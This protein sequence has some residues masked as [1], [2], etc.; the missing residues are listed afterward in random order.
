M[1]KEFK[2]FA[3]K[4]NVLDMAVGII[5]GAAFGKIISSLVADI[6]MPPVG[7]MMGGLDFSNLFLNL[8]GGEYPQG[9]QGRGR[10]DDQRG[11]VPQH[12]HRFLDC[13]DRD[14]FAGAQ[15]EPHASARRGSACGAVHEALPVVLVVEPASHSCNR[16][17]ANLVLAVRHPWVVDHGFVILERHAYEGDVLAVRRP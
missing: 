5:I 14:L 8:S 6:I 9:R 11:R 16:R 17:T 10:G 2:E 7:R 15:R 13:R 3:M 1:L 4:G 12:G